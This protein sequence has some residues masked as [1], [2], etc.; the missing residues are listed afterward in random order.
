MFNS[1]KVK[2]LEAEI[3]D[4]KMITDNQ[5]FIWRKQLEKIEWFLTQDNTSQRRKIEGTLKFVR[6]AKACLGEI[7]PKLGEAL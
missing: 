6:T 3:A 1:K 4:L 7:V 2:R 5:S